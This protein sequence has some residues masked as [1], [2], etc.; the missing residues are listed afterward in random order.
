MFTVPTILTR[1]ADAAGTSDRSSLRHVV[2][3]GAPM[4]DADRDRA[5]R[6]LGPVLVQYYG[7]GEVTGNITVLTP[8]EH[9]HPRPA[10]VGVSTCGR[11]RTGM[12]VAVLGAGGAELGPGGIGEICVAGP[13]VCAGYLGY[14]GATASAF[15]GGWFHT[16][17]LGTVDEH[18]YLYITGR[19]SEMYISGG[20]NVYPRDIEEKL[21]AHPA[22]AE[23]AVLGVPDP[24]WGESGVAVWVARPGADADGDALREWLAPRL[25]RYKLPRRFVRRAEL[26]RSGYGKVLKRVLRDELIDGR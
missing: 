20:S 7:L 5:L 3:A 26:P 1:L 25:A 10:G 13:A 8:A 16:G 2:Y 11:P 12:Q 6:T 4:P 24:E 19:A 22:V 18:G 9:G 14:P 15:A 17:D 21:A 23:V